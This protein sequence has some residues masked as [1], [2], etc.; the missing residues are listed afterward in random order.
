MIKEMNSKKERITD[1]H[2]LKVFLLFAVL[3]TGCGGMICKDKKHSIAF[4]YDSF[5]KT[6][7]IRGMP[8]YLERDPWVK[9]ILV[10]EAGFIVITEQKTAGFKMLPCE[11]NSKKGKLCQKHVI[12]SY[13]IME[14][15]KEEEGYKSWSHLPKAEWTSFSNIEARPSQKP[16]LHIKNCRFSFFGS[17]FE[18]FLSLIFV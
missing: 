5:F 17:L 15:Y 16:D 18:T 4:S 10:E 8:T 2:L 6:I 11:D 12:S 9:K 7:D 13:Y 14:S 3:L 1:Y